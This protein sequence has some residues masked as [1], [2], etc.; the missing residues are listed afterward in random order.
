MRSSTMVLGQPP[1]R[2]PT[3]V[4]ADDVA[5]QVQVRVCPLGQPASTGFDVWNQAAPDET[6][7]WL[8]TTSMTP[9]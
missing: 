5:L 7:R 6:T 2:S 3:T 1:D 4:I 9:K 8:Q